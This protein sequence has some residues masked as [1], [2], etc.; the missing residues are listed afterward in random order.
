MLVS[1]VCM[2]IY[3]NFYNPVRLHTSLLMQVRAVMVKWLKDL[4]LFDH[5]LQGLFKYLN[6]D[7]DKS[8]TLA[9]EII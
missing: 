3:V 1:E 7:S 2:Y 5:F 9:G 8:T 6:E 4:S